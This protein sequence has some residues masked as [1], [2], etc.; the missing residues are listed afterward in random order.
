MSNRIE[1]LTPVGRLVQGSLYEP[2]TTD[3]E[4]KPLTIR[5]GPNGGQPRVDFYFALA[6]PKGGE[7]HWSQT[8]WGAKIWQAG[9]VGFPNGQT[10]SPT[11]AWK[12]TDGDSQVPNRMGKKPADRE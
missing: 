6:V 4:N 9:H 11:F 12:V 3:A 7:Q 8:Q 1:L 5:S 2:Q 10:Q